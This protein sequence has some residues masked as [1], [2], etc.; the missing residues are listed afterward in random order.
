MRGPRLAGLA[1]AFLLLA[2][3]ARAGLDRDLFLR[4]FDATVLGGEHDDAPT[5]A[6]VLK[7][8]TP[9]VI[10]LFGEDAD[11]WLHF[12]QGYAAE[13]SALTGLRVTAEKAAAPRDIRE[14][15]HFQL[16]ILPRRDFPQLVAQSWIPAG[17]R[18]GLSRSM[19]FFVTFG[20][21]TVRA[22]LIAVDQGLA[23]ETLRHCL[24]EETAQAFGVVND[25]RLAGASIFNDRGPLMAEPT[26]LD[27][28][29]LRVLYDPRLAPGTPREQAL[30]MAGEIFDG[31]VAGG[32]P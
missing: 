31:L 1:A 7:A 29:V 10:E 6:H 3:P 27:R 9:I 12:M 28:M 20:R 21:D 14:G 23:P 22:A 2:A 5:R 16:H 4:F 25:S 17:W 8:T 26:E 18:A 11:A 19:C 32:A 13:L 30:A 15:G 24:L